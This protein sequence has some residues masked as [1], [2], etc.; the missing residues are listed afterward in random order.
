MTAE[1]K[2]AVV[3][4]LKGVAEFQEKFQVGKIVVMRRQAPHNDKTVISALSRASLLHLAQGS[5]NPGGEV[6]AALNIK[7]NAAS[8]CTIL[9][10]LKMCLGIAF[11]G[12]S[13]ET[14]STGAALGTYKGFKG[15]YVKP[16][17][18]S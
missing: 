12:C 6:A 1:A 4:E 13:I 10:N 17:N 16:G 15:E 11:P 2:A 14:N 7:V 8:W 9:M 18:A 3:A 5:K